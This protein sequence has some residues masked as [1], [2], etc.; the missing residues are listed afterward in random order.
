MTDFQVSDAE[1]RKN[2]AQPHLFDRRARRQ[3]TEDGRQKTEGG[4][5]RTEDRGQKKQWA[6]DSGRSAV[7]KYGAVIVARI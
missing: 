2:K 5:Q 3:R 7:K 6:V 1:Q 4:G